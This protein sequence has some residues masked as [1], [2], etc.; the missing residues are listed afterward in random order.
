MKGK[1]FFD[2][3]SYAIL[4]SVAFV[5]PI[6]FIPVSFISVQFGTSLFFAFGVILAILVYVTQTLGLGFIELPSPS[7][8]VV[9]F[10]SVVPV[11]Y[12]LSAFASGFSRMSLF[13]YTFDIST[14][15]F[16]ILGFIYL[17]LVSIFFRD[18]KRIFYSYFAFVIS[19]LAL[20][21][22]LLVRI[23]FGPEILSFGIFTSITATVVG[24]WNNVGIFFGIGVIL[25]LLTHQMLH[26]S[27]LMK[28]LLI[29]AL[30]SSLFFLTLVNFKIIWIILAVCSV[31][32][33]LYNLFSFHGSSMSS[34]S[35]GKK[36]KSIPIYPSA[37]LMLSVVFIIWGGALGSYIS[38]MFGVNNLDVRPTFST[39]LNIARNTIIQKPVFGSGP[40]TF[41]AQW[42]AFK[43]DDVI[44]TIF[45]DTDFTNGIGLIPTFAVTTGLAGILSWLLFLGFYIYLGVKSIFAKIDSSFVKYLLVSSFFVSLYLWIMAFVYVPSTVIFILTFF[46][47]GLFFASVYLADIIHFKTIVFSR[48]PKAGFIWSLVLV[49][50]LAVNLGLAY[51]LFKNSKSMWYFQ[52]S[53]YALNTKNDTEASEAYMASAITAVPYDIYFRALT[54]IELIKLNKIISEDPAKQTRPEL[55]QKIFADTLASAIKA[56]LASK[57]ADPKNY[58]NWISLG[59]V[60]EAV[61]APSLKVQGAFESAK[62]A[63]EEALHRNPK[64]P[65]ILV[66]LARLH[67]IK[68]DYK[69]ARDYAM[70]AI[71]A[72]SN[73]LDAY[74]LLSQIEVA[75]KNINGAIDSV[76]AASMINPTD[77]AIFFQL[78]LLKYNIKDYRGAI[79]SL[80]KATKLT[81]NYAN[82]R[83]FLGLSYEQVGE[84]EKAIQEFEGLKIT[85]PDNKDVL[86]IL[87]NLKEGKSIFTD[88][89]DVKSEKVGTLPIKEKQ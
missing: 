89:E 45:W 86:T 60:Y 29:I 30:F 54:E 10:T 16:V 52:K 74:F 67:T 83:Y 7:K 33:I 24:S 36:L 44:S 48:N 19:S 37:V 18:E 20:S 79:N 31:L 2:K 13:G 70:Q 9:G 35:I 32:F 8:Y 85:N 63:Y 14:V 88:T 4:L 56:G 76:T 42:L 51:G 34:L 40:N 78:G 22:F 87:T 73:Y 66:L 3:F 49:S 62:F 1:V 23:I 69:G 58:L 77:P 75:D 81:P 17:F 50:V 25:S 5:A 43:P 6:F 27:R 68:Q 65:G 55:I 28:I 84:R 57:D 59:K 53:S 11:A 47:T 80:E 39:T 26:V 15:G 38:N 71:K 72:K 41:L 12:V 64:N 61:S 82:A 21:I 46:F